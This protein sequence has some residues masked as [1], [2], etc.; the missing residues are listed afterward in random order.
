MKELSTDGS[1]YNLPVT[2]DQGQTATPRDAGA[3]TVVWP[4]DKL[5]PITHTH[6]VSPGVAG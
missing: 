5:S 6:R 4:P 2:C 1:V 3:S